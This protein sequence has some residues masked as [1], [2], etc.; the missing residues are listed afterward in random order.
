MNDF[1]AKIGVYLTYEKAMV[2]DSLQI[3]VINL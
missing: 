2:V 3:D 1:K